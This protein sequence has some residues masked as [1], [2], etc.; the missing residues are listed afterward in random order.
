VAQ[1]HRVQDKCPRTRGA[2]EGS[3]AEGV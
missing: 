3:M 1:G 2:V